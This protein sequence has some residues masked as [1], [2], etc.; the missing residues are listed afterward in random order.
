MANILI[1]GGTG[2]VGTRL[3][4]VLSARGHEVRVLSRSPKGHQQ[5]FKAFQWNL[6]N[7]IVDPAALDGI[8]GVI[9]LAGAGI[10]D[11]RWSDARKRLIISSR[12]DSA[13]LIKSALRNEG[14]KPHFFI[15]ASGSNYYGTQ[16]SAHVFTETDAAGNDF[17]GSCCALW[18]GAAFNENPAARVVALR[19][20]V[21]FSKTGGA[22]EKLVPPIRFW[23]GAP[24]GS[25]KQYV[26]W[27]HLN[28]LV[29]MYVKA[30]E[31]SSVSGAYNAVAPQH[32]TQ[33]DQTTI[34]ASV[35]KKLL[36]LPNVPAFVLKAVLGEM[37]SIVLE[38]SRLS[39][40][41]IQRAGFAFKYD[42]AEAA[43]EDVLTTP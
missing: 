26:P 16:T 4:E 33:S 31:D 20:G 39:A 21:V 40:D 22:L 30:V 7:G 19:T 13:E 18:E 12:V 28:D 38:G 15:T 36:W 8:D 5:G 17:L 32:L 23:L 34:I 2:L 37:S 42:T 6:K 27:I 10:A 41:K 11:S 3:C 24:L 9:H 43:L 14:I 25:G 29:N 1:S 35:L